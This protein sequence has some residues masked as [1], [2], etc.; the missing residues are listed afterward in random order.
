MTHSMCDT[1]L[2]MAWFR[3]CRWLTVSCADGKEEGEGCFHVRHSDYMSVNLSDYCGAAQTLSSTDCSTRLRKCLCTSL[4]GIVNSL[5][6]MQAPKEAL[7]EREG[8]ALNGKRAALD[9]F[10]NGRVSAWSK[11]GAYADQKRDDA[12]SL[13]HA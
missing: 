9:S 13:E 4:H 12:E 5:E 7:Q 1:A 8:T 2:S 6:V 11:Q 10:M 3:S